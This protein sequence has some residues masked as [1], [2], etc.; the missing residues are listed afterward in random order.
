MNEGILIGGNDTGQMIPYPSC[1]NRES[2]TKALVRRLARSRE[3]LQATVPA[4][5]F[6]EFCR[7][8]N[9]NKPSETGR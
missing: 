6:V 7:I 3:P 1:A 4:E 2:T 5:R 8:T 9:S